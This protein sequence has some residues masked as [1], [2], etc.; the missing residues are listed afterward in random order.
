MN[1]TVLRLAHA[2]S[3]NMEGEGLIGYIATGHQGGVVKINLTLICV[4]MCLLERSFQSLEF[5][6]KWIR[7]PGT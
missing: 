6:I 7:P 5:E 2:P 1:V 4:C 3:A